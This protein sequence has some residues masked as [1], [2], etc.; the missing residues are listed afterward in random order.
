VKS[1]FD[2]GVFEHAVNRVQA[3]QPSAPRQWGKMT[4]AQMLEHTARVLEMA[5]GKGPQKQIWPGKLFSWTFRRTF[6]GEKPFGKNAPT[7]RD[8]VIQDEPDFAAVKNR[9]LAV[10]QELQ[11]QGERGCDGHVHTFFGRL[12]GAQWGETQYKHLDHHLRQFGG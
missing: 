8:F 4:P 11:S 3:L 9:L 12:S 6:L 2:P 7:G 5:C 10:M 1:L